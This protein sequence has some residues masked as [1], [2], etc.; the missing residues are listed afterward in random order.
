MDIV[1]SS[2]NISS[3]NLSS[4]CLAVGTMHF[5]CMLGKAGIT[6]DKREGDHATP[7]GIFP[8]RR[9]LFRPDR[10]KA[11]PLT[12]L[13]VTPLGPNDGWC[14][15]PTHRD[16]NRPVTLPHPARHEKLWRDDRAYDIIVVIG[17]N[18][19]PPIAGKG[20]AI[21]M[22]LTVPA[23]SPAHGWR[24][25]EGCIALDTPDMLA[26]LAACTPHSRLII[27]KT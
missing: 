16:Y 12:A 15:D 3:G 8:L 4:G 10:L 23:E 22:H 27:H 25:T 20:S 9:V 13:P 14:D 19:A 24:A 11:A 1:V 17:H 26:L 2:S 7:R 6:A 21:F 18:D 5:P